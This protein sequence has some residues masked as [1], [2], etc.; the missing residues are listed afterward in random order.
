MRVFGLSAATA[1]RYS[2]AAHPDKFRLDP[3]RP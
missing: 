1:M 2:I 3:I